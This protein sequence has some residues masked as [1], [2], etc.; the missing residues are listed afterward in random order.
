MFEPEP[1]GDNCMEISC[2]Y[3]KKG[4]NYFNG[5]MESGGFYL[6]FNKGKF[7]TRD[8]YN[9]FQHMMFDGYKIKVADGERD[10]K[11]KCEKLLNALVTQELAQAAFDGDKRKVFDMLKTVAA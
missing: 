11:K 5:D 9:S 1:S 3:R 10:N 6:S 8:G 2:F 7:E 4:M